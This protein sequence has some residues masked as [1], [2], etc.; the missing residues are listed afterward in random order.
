MCVQ[1]F[2][3]VAGEKFSPK[4]RRIAKTIWFLQ[5]RAAAGHHFCLIE[6][7]YHVI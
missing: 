3:Y 4:G 1:V 7:T 6:S 5:S 2:E